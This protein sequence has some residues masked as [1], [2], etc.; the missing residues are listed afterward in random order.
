MGHHCHWDKSSSLRS[1]LPAC[2]YSSHTLLGQ[3]VRLMGS[4]HWAMT[5]R[6]LDNN[7][8]CQGPLQCVHWQPV[9]VP[10]SG[11]SLQ[12]AAQSTAWWTQEIKMPFSSFTDLM[13]I[14][15][16]AQ[17]G[18]FLLGHTCLQQ[19]LPSPW[20]A[21][22]PDGHG[23]ADNVPIPLTLPLSSLTAK[24]RGACQD[25]AKSAAS[26][27]AGTC[28]GTGRQER[29]KAAYNPP[30]PRQEPAK[31]CSSGSLLHGLVLVWRI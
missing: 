4:Y 6:P 3:P 16:P 22:C 11:P 2:N 12:K 30:V 23:K 28:S 18:Q 7:H 27:H 8:S 20:A 17:M 5:R 31:S 19:R 15:R 25:K 1:G 14:F 21:G 10:N 26:S 29:R 9:A 13:T 24:I